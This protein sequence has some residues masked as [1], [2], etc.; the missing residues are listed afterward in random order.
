MS[1]IAYTRGRERR[2][3]AGVNKRYNDKEYVLVSFPH[4]NKHSVIPCH[5][6]DRDPLEKQNGSIKTFGTRKNF[7]IVAEGMIDSDLFTSFFPFAF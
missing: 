2:S 7:R 5:S 1:S 4:A 6:I 3:T